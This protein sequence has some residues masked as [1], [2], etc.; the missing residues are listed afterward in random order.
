MGHS[1]ISPATG[2]CFYAADSFYFFMSSILSL[3]TLMQFG[4]EIQILN[5][6]YVL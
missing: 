1:D 2:H 3:G 4:M 6:F 5:Q